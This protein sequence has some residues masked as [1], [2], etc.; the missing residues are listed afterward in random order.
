MVKTETNFGIIGKLKNIVRKT[1]NVFF[2]GDRD[3]GITEEIARKIQKTAYE[4]LHSGHKETFTPPYKHI[5]EQLQVTDDMIYRA[6]V[7]RLTHIAANEDKLAADILSIL[8][9]QLQRTD[10]SKEQ[11]DYIRDKIMYIKKVRNSKP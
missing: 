2:R 3:R 11:Q 7:Y 5:A 6:A 1:G 9:L 10:R 4:T 8:E